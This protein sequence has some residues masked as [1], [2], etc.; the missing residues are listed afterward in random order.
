MDDDHDDDET[1]AMSI[2]EGYFHFGSL[3]KYIL[4][5]KKKKE[6]ITT[7]FDL[8]YLNNSKENICWKKYYPIKPLRSRKNIEK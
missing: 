3:I 2:F 8:L 4:T 5:K 7:Y 1:Q 6:I